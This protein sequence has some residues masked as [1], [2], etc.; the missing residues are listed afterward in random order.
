MNK[1]LETAFSALMT[2]SAVLIA[3]SVFHRSFFTD[4][5]DLHENDEEIQRVE[6]WNQLLR[7]GV[8]IGSAAAPVQIIEF[9]DFECPFCRRFHLDVVRVMAEFPGEIALVYYHF[10][11]SQHRFAEPAA[12]AAE[13]SRLEDRFHPMAERLFADEDSL[14]LK[15]WASYARSAGVRD[16]VA[17][18][19][20]MG[21]GEIQARIDANRTFAR[22]LSVRGTPTVIING[23]RFGRP[24]SF[25]S[26][27]SIAYAVIDGQS[28]FPDDR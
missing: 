23:W 4:Q 11:L 16:T 2:L 28:P 10:P 6:D 3:G 12:R 13:C 15:S 22:R 17:L 27:R 8:R 9:G 24:P 19:E 7:N 26:I 25:D 1:R 20:C 21:R 5:V 18:N 14:G